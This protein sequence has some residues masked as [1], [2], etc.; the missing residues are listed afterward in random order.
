MKT[1][2]V[3]HSDQI[4]EGLAERVDAIVAAGRDAAD[5]IK[6]NVVAAKDAVVET[7]GSLAHALAK[8]IKA[9]PFTSVMIAFG[10]GYIVTRLMRMRSAS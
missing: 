6:V 3:T 7:S 1:A 5:E 8:S 10:A 9:R 2:N 4:A